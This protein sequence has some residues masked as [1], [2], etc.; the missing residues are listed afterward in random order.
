M[1]TIP[2]LG[3][4]K[5]IKTRLI[6]TLC[7]H[8]GIS[9]LTKK[10][11]KPGS[12]IS[13]PVLSTVSTSAFSLLHP[14]GKTLAERERERGRAMEPNEEEDMGIK[15]EEEEEEMGK[16]LDVHRHVTT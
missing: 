12:C 7:L 16:P 1:L 6:Y 2:F 5:N 15:E 14:H 11:R 8:L 9:G 10:N 4:L 13:W 3:N